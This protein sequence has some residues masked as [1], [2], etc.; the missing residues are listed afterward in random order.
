VAEDAATTEWMKRVIPIWERVLGLFYPEVC[1]ICRTE[2]ATAQEGYVCANCWSGP[3]GVRFIVPP[4]CEKCGWHYDGNITSEFTCANCEGQTLHFRRARA[5]VKLAAVVQE[6]VHKYKYNNALWFE[7]FL[8]DLLV[9]QA[10]PELSRE[11]W[12]WIVP[13]P[14]HWRKRRE[15]GFNQAETL[16]GVLSKASGIAVNKT[17]LV[18]VTPT[19]TQTR[20]TR[21]Q[22][23]ENVRRAF[24]YEGK[25]RL[26]G[27]RLILVDDVLTTGATASACAKVLK[28]NG[29]GEVDVWTVARG[30]VQ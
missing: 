7:P 1:Q 12:D 27:E 14:L 29:A 10:R 28:D 26:K 15:R 22:R 2:S 9:R 21:V 8:G 30:G 20:L 18:R 13:I 3:A 16:A 24:A 4:F 19:P 11:R 6:A 5:A 25:E 23:M 17:F